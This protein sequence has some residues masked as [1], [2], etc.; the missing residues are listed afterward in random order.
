LTFETAKLGGF[1]VGNN[2]DLSA[3]ELFGGVV[4][5]YARADLALLR[6]EVDLKQHEFV[7][8]G[9][10]FRGFDGRNFELHFSEF[11]DGNHSEPFLAAAV[12]LRKIAEGLCQRKF[13]KAVEGVLQEGHSFSG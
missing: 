2:N 8:V 6:A 7:C 1:E 9:M 5:S 10:R 12:T 11:I 13:F 4:I 3:Y